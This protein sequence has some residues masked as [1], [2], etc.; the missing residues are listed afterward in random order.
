MLICEGEVKSRQCTPHP[1]MSMRFHVCFGLNL[2]GNNLLP[3][4]ASPPGIM[5]S[6]RFLL[7]EVSDP[8]I[9]RP[10]LHLQQ[11]YLNES[12]DYFLMRSSEILLFM[13]PNELTEAV[14]HGDDT[15]VTSDS[16]MMNDCRK[17]AS[18]PHPLCMPCWRYIWCNCQAYSCGCMPSPKSRC[19]IWSAM[20][21][22]DNI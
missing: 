7:W 2:W 17:L 20:K 21:W 6:L 18:P 1:I 19:E 16:A 12:G 14:S 5:T 22:S 4:P 8:W 3:L 11:G 10:A 15:H 13:S 9:T